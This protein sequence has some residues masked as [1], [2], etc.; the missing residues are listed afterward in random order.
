L[1]FHQDIRRVGDVL[2]LTDVELRMLPG[3]SATEVDDVQR[4]LARYGLQ[5][6]P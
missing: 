4:A 6:H 2:A 1:L 5:L 3:M